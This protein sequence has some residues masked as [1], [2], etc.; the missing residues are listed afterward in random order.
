[1]TFMVLQIFVNLFL[2]YQT[3]GMIVFFRNSAKLSKQVRDTQKYKASKKLEKRFQFWV[4]VSVT[5]ATFGVIMWILWYLQIVIRTQEQWVV[6]W[7]FLSISKLGNV[8][9]QIQVCR[10]PERHASRETF[11]SKGDSKLNGGT[12]SH[13]SKDI[14]NRGTRKA[15]GT[16]ETAQ[17]TADGNGTPAFNSS[18]P[19]VLDQEINGN[20]S[21]VVQTIEL[22]FINRS[23]IKETAKGKAVSITGCN[24]EGKNIDQSAEAQASTSPD[25]TLTSTSTSTSI[26][27]IDQMD[28]IKTDTELMQS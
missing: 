3:W 4:T 5:S 8:L 23:A 26:S 19:L 28:K 27:K 12:N 10:P 9:A 18:S 14:E 7:T 24:K 15:N 17:P 25:T 11:T 1:M 22:Q 13:M 6:L 21:E 16:I 2:I 20:Q